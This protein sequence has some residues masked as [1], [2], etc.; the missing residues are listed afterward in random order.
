MELLKKITILFLLISGINSYGQSKKV[1]EKMPQAESPLSS[2]TGLITYTVEF[3]SELSDSVLYKRSSHWYQNT[4][5]SMRIQPEEC[6]S[7]NKIVAKGEFNYMKPAS[8]K[9]QDVAGR[10][11]YTMNTYIEN[12]KVK[13]EITRF[14]IQNTNYMPIEPWLEQQKEDYLFKYYLINTEEQAQDILR[15]YKE[16]VDVEY[17]K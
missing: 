1:I 7:P 13:T 10:L 5:K 16:F 12:G 6:S 3:K 17:V 9:G 15:Q 11:K 2:E 4:I 8:K 14:N